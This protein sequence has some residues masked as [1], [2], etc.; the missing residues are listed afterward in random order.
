MYSP[1]LS[2][3]LVR[4]LYFIKEATGTPMTKLLDRIV[5]DALDGVDVEVDGEK[6]VHCEKKVA[7]YRL[8]VR[9]GKQAPWLVNGAGKKEKLTP[10]GQNASKD[11]APTFLQ[12][13][14]GPV[15]TGQALGGN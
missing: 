5:R 10:E 8:Q 2:D 3:D 11:E 15:G 14:S 9:E 4:K 13:T 1:T 6:K 7:A 12:A